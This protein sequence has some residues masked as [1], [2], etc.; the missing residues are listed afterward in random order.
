MKPWRFPVLNQ[1]NLDSANASTDD[2]SNSLAINHVHVW[3]ARLAEFAQYKENLTSVLSAEEKHR[4]SRFFQP[5]DRER[6]VLRRGLL[7]IILSG[8]TGFLPST[9]QFG[10]EYNGK[11]VLPS[12]SAG[13]ALHFNL[14]HSN[15]V[16]VY[17][18]SA[19]GEVG[20]DVEQI[21]NLPDWQDFVQEH[22]SNR[23][24]AVL[25]RI[26]ENRRL[27]AFYRGWTRKEAYLK[28]TGQG[29]GDGLR[30][31]EVSLKPNKPP[32]IR[33]IMGSTASVPEWTLIDLPTFPGFIGALAV[34]TILAEVDFR[35][36]QARVK[37]FR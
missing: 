34:R 19:W 16:A 4:S 20:I 7:R 3:C 2:L 14:S 27:E 33:R 5:T 10:H 13:R 23:E 36:C 11:P 6:F 30:Q 26:P 21:R 17:A 29:L 35:I 9:I 1:S 8:Y 12:S 37:A 28:A 31:I 22:F 18:V 32:E 24:Q 25:R 15:G